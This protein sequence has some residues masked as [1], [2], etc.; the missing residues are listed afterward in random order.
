MFG[1]HVLSL[2]FFSSYLIISLPFVSLSQGWVEDS[3]ISISTK[4]HH[5]PE[6]ES[7]LSNFHHAGDPFAD[8][9]PGSSDDLLYACQDN[10]GFLLAHQPAMPVS[11][12]T[13]GPGINTLDICSTIGKLQEWLDYVASARDRNIV[14]VAAIT[15]NS[16]EVATRTID[17][18]TSPSIAYLNNSKTFGECFWPL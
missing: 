1:N 9:D 11:Y 17:D 7:G 4:F 5:S 6:S 16:H 10:V 3:I 2:R 18:A 13:T 14:N 8:V 12:L 15:T